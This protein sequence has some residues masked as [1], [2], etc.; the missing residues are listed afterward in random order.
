V[1]HYVR[2]FKQVLSHALASF[3]IQAGRKGGLTGVWVGDE[4][5]AAIVVES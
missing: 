4:W 1:H 5:I 2:D 3:G